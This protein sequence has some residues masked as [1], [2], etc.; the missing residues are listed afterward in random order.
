MSPRAARR[1]E[2]ARDM[3]KLDRAMP[4]DDVLTA[5]KHTV[6]HPPSLRAAVDWVE[7]YE[8]GRHGERQRV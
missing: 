4:L 5:I 2:I 1:L 6:A 7:D 3:L 8:R